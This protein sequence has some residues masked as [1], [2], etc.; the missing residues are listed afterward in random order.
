MT[1]ICGTI[2]CFL[3]LLY[4]VHKQ[5]EILSEYYHCSPPTIGT[6][7]IHATIISCLNHNLSLCCLPCRTV[8]S[9]T[10]ANESLKYKSD[11][12]TLKLNHCW[13]PPALPCPHAGFPITLG[14][15]STLLN[16]TYKVL[17]VLLFPTFSLSFNLLQP[18]GFIASS[19]K[20]SLIS[21]LES[22]L[23]FVFLPRQFF[24]RSLHV[25]LL[26][27]VLNSASGTHLI[28]ETFPNPPPEDR[29]RGFI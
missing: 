10:A 18:Q 2:L 19:Q 9:P 5:T 8:Y 26:H 13:P 1:K 6:S 3:F 17:H 4:L 28:R 29:G 11:H 24:Q 14:M 21:A 20:A 22:L 16:M 23:L 27:I 15:K 7:L 12:V 25:W